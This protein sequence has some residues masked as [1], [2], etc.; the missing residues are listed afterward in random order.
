[1]GKFSQL[2][3]RNTPP[4]IPINWADWEADEHVEEMDE[5]MEGIYFRIV[6]EL[7]KYDQFEFNYTRLASRIRVKDARRV[8]TFLERWGHV[9]RCVECGG[10]PT[11]RW[12]HA[13]TL[14]HPCSYCAAG[15]QCSCN[16]L[17]VFVQHEK[18]KNYKDTAISSS[19]TGTKQYNGN[20]AN[21]TATEPEP[22][23]RVVPVSEKE[24]E[25]VREPVKAFDSDSKGFDPLTFDG[26]VTAAKSG[27]AYS[28]IEV[29]RILDYHFKHNRSEYWTDPAKGNI[30]SLSRLAQ[31]IDTM[32]EQVPIDWT[33]PAP[34]PPRPKGD[35][36][37]RKCFGRG[38][39]TVRS[40]TDLSQ[41]A[42]PCGCTR[43]ETSKCSDTPTVDS[44]GAIG[45]ESSAPQADR[46]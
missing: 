29:R 1:M 22:V 13:A 38:L 25:T 36:N 3:G 26:S 44:D 39:V 24:S 16:T 30:T 35:P 17:A 32:A 33:P 14:Q 41:M 10:T 21:S 2:E 46:H 20:K 8:R 11:P 12:E 9:F 4:L 37:C 31:A 7:W 5:T 28:S 34:K 19:G 42:E 6:R 18:L 23:A 45:I 40:N 43:V 15:V 27:K